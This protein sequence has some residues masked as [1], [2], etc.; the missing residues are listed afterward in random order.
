ME[1]KLIKKPKSK[2]YHFL[3]FVVFSF[4]VFA[5]ICNAE[6]P[7][8]Q[9]KAKILKEIPIPIVHIKGSHYE[10]SYQLGTNLKNNI[11]EGGIA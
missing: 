7:K 8:K 3:I 9:K 6:A 4:L 2:S 1:D 10:V 5:F 11:I